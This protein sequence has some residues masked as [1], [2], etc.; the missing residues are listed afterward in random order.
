MTPSLSQVFMIAGV[1]GG[2]T[3]LLMGLFVLIFSPLFRT[4]SIPDPDEAS[5]PP[6]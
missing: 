3:L 6:T 4:D 2:L 5:P 1:A